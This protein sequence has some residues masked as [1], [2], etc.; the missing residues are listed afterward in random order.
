MS[1]PL[2]QASD[3][4]PAR[5]L[6]VSELTTRIKELLE[7][8]FSSFW[9]SGEISNFKRHTSGHIYLTLKD[10]QAQISAVIWRSAASRLVFELCDGLEVVVHGRISLYEPQGKY[11]VVIDEIQ[12]KGLGALELAFRQLR[13]KLESE[14]LFAPEHKKPLPRFPRRIVLVTSPVGAAVR[15][16]LQVIGRRWR[17]VELLVRPVRVQGEGA[18]LEIAEAIAEVNQLDAVDL[19]IVGR[20]GGSLEDLWAFNEEIVA[21]AIFNSRVPVVSAVGHEVDLTI[22]DLVADRRAL[23]P[24]EAGELVVPN[25]SEL[26]ETL[27][28][29]ATRIGR[30][31]QD[32]LRAAKS[33]LGVL[34]SRRSL[35]Y[36][37]DGVRQLQQRCDELTGR[38]QAAI[39]HRLRDAEHRLA[40]LAAI[41][42][43][44][45]PLKVLARGYS[46]TMRKEDQTVLRDAAETR[47][48]D[49]LVTRLSRGRLLSLVEETYPE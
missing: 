47:A 39:A 13:G 31:L 34:S 12:P 33:L 7:F 1:L 14:G 49:R 44:L 21:R 48:G 22:A 23:T 38:L 32:R 43:S 35:R 27:R 16:M 19:M 28:Q 45:S 9:L 2:L 18:A 20:G 46:L 5:V 8:E 25:E 42:E 3:G 36:P 4:A 26:R 37:Y 15:D 6:S 10:D 17:A 30:V 29:F 11:Q 41:A 24:S 40:R